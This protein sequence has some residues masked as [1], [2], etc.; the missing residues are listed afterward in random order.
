MVTTN[1]VLYHR[2]NKDGKNPLAIRITKSRKS[3]YVFLGQVIDRKDWDEVNKKV[4]RS[5][6]N[7]NRLNAFL[8]KKL[9]EVNKTYLSKEIEEEET[10]GEEDALP[11]PPKLTRS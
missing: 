8:V 9:A 6:P 5:H 11:T 7:S 10:T 2:P 1:L 3:S 4:R